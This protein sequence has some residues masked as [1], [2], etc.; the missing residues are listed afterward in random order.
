MNNKFLIILL[1]LS[2]SLAAFVAGYLIIQK[3]YAGQPANLAW[4]S[5]LN[6]FEEDKTKADDFPKDLVALSKGGVIS[7][8]LS[9]EKDSLIYYNELDGKVFQ[10]NPA[11]LKEVLVSGTSLTNL[12]R[13][14]W[15]P[16]RKEVIS[17]FYTPEGEKFKYYNYQTR[18][19]VD[20]GPQVQ[21]AAFSP[22]GSHLAYFKSQGTDGAIYISEPDG[23]SPKKI[24]D[25]RISDLE[26]FWPSPENLVFKTNTD[27][28]DR[29]FTVST[30]GNLTK[31]LEKAGQIEILWSPDDTKILY[32][33]KDVGGT[34]LMVKDVK[35]S[36]DTSLQVAV[37][38]PRCAWGINAAYLICSVPRSGAGEDIYKINLDGTK[39]LIASPKKNLVTKQL[40]LTVLEE[41][42]VIVNDL[43]GKLYAL[44]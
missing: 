14:I 6:K 18:K 31:I 34:T 7:P 25:T 30:T 16:D 39:E 17:V 24:L 33:V 19:V 20:L 11:D 40:M 41:F 44:K 15:S 42:I 23:D 37:N 32:S 35:T 2:L 3:D 5:I 27:G 1:A 26:L 4:D 21:S 38:V 22:D 28:S 8:V 10:V 13:T 12:V 43:D 36:T 29:V 9:K